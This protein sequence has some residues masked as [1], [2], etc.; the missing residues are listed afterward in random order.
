M[1]NKKLKEDIILAVV[2]IITQLICDLIEHK[3]K[4]NS[5][6]EN[7]PEGQSKTE[8]QKYVESRLSK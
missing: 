2:P 8:F 3:V 5:S 6:K 1:N 7:R 4:E